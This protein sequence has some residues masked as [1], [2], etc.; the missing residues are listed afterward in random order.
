[1]KVTEKTEA[2]ALQHSHEDS[3][4]VQG[5]MEQQLIYQD[6]ESKSP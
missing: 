6:E 2:T 1:M 5:L 4:D 3:R